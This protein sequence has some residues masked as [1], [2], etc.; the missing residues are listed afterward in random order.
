MRK[1]KKGRRLNITNTKTNVY[2]TPNVV[3]ILGLNYKTSTLKND[4]PVKT[5]IR[6]TVDYDRFLP[7]L[8]A[9]RVVDKAHVDR[10]VG[11]I[12][13]DGQKVPIIVNE[14]DDVIEGQHRVLACKKLHHPIAYMV[15]DK[16]SIKDT[17][18]MNN[19]Q[20]PWKFNDYLK[21]YSHFTH[22]NHFE[23]KKIVKFIDD[24]NLN[25]T[26]SLTLL[27]L[28]DYVRGRQRFKDGDFQVENLQKAE[29]QA[30][31]LIRIKAFS[32]E[33]V[34]SVK[35]AIALG[36]AQK[37]Q[38]FKIEKAVKQIEKNLGQ[39]VNCNNQE[40]WFNTLI[41]YPNGVYNKGL[42]KKDKIS[43]NKVEAK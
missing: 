36:Q 1:P 31:L 39:F 42:P 6:T 14:N 35:F 8:P 23:Y 37:I 43:N 41:K 18:K 26:V 15:C 7:F 13:D 4:D 9:N 11:L 10:L 5:E 30:K 38:G 40:S 28:S 33:L 25:N 16:A 32:S 19:S 12:N 29:T 20:K 3:S 21:S 24:Y 2:S 34:R 17:R 22:Y 27:C